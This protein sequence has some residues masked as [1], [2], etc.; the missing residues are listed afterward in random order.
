M[1]CRK[2]PDWTAKSSYSWID[3]DIESNP[4]QVFTDSAVGSDERMWV[5]FRGTADSDGA[6]ITVT[7]TDPP[8]YEIGHCHAGP[9]EITL[10]HGIE[11]IW[12]ISKSRTSLILHCNGVEISNYEFSESEMTDCANIWSPQTEDA[13]QFGIN[14]WNVQD[15]ASDFYRSYPGTKIMKCS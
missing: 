4:L 9:T 10:P 6:G 3:Y 11:R 2:S 15:T 14:R 13:F 7:F 5:R 1:T 8:S 12:T